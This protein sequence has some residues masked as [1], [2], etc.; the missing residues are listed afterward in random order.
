[1]K[2]KPKFLNV[3]IYPHTRNAKIGENYVTAQKTFFFLHLSNECKVAMIKL[4]GPFSLLSL[5]FQI[6]FYVVFSVLLMIAFGWVPLYLRRRRR[7]NGG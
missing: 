7:F 3:I 2:I 5:Y 6:S 4:T 1:M